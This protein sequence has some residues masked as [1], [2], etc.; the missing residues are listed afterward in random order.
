MGRNGGYEAV[1]SYKESLNSHTL[2]CVKEITT[3]EEKKNWGRAW[4]V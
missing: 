3:K 2:L 1:V 4:A